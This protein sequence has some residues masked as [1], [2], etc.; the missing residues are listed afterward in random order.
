LF[1]ILPNLAVNFAF[2]REIMAQNNLEANKIRV[3]GEICYA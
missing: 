3:F 2:E 1:D